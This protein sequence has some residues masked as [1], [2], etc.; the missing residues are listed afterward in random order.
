VR[1]LL[2]RAI[3][4][5]VHRAV[6]PQVDDLAAGRLQDPPHDVDRRVVAVEQRGGGHETDLVLRLV[7]ERWAAR[8]VHGVLLARC[9]SRPPGGGRGF[10]KEEA[11]PLA[12][13][14]DAVRILNDVYVNVNGHE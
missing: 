11:Y 14:S 10:P 9:R 12:S 2:D 1:I 4:D 8:V 3:D 5:L 6:V 7:D 13:V